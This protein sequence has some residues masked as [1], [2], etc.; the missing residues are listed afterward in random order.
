MP[1]RL[2]ARRLLYAR[3]GDDGDDHET[4]Q[5]TRRTPALTPKVFSMVSNSTR[6]SAAPQESR[7]IGPAA[8]RVRIFRIGTGALYVMAR[9]PNKRTGHSGSTVATLTTR[10]KREGN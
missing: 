2:S 4:G 10:K 1:L 5:G 8:R 3:S 6:N 7:H 9:D